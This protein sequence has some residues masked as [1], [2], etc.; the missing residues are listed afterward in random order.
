MELAAE[1]VRHLRSIVPLSVTEIKD[2]TRFAH[3]ISGHSLDSLSKL[4]YD[5]FQ[6]IE[7]GTDVA[8]RNEVM[9]K[10]LAVLVPS[11]SG[12]KGSAIK[13]FICLSE[14]SPA[15]FTQR[16]GW[17]KSILDMLEER[18]DQLGQ[19]TVYAGY[20]FATILVKSV[21]DDY[22]AISKLADAMNAILGQAGLSTNTFLVAAENSQEGESISRVAVEH[23][24]GGQG[25]RMWLPELFQDYSLDESVRDR[26]TAFATKFLIHDKESLATDQKIALQAF[27]R[28][29][30]V[31]DVLSAMTALFPQFVSM[32]RKF[33]DTFLLMAPPGTSKY[34]EILSKVDPRSETKSPYTI[35]LSISI[36][37]VRGLL[38]CEHKLTEGALNRIVRVRNKIMHGA[39]LDLGNEWEDFAMALVELCKCSSMCPTGGSLSAVAVHQELQP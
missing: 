23:L 12:I 4:S 26:L 32:E 7:D 6:K 3:D 36:K 21:A 10:H 17:L 29:V 39:N 14:S 35:P 11:Y 24:Q 8:K 37:A 18:K 22:Y 30:V 5:Q 1:N 15:T 20:G 27:L 28:A 2:E 13:F 34:S 9:E 25:V 33:R 19:R 31:G 38:N 16:A